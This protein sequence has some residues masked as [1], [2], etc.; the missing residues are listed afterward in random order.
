MGGDRPETTEARRFGLT[1]LLVVAGLAGI[2][3][4]LLRVAHTCARQAFGLAHA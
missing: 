2:L 4:G 1:D 3:F